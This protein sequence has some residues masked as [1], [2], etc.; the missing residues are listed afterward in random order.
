MGSVSIEESRR[1]DPILY[2]RFSYSTWVISANGGSESLQ[3][4]WGRKQPGG[5]NQEVERFSYISPVIGPIVAF[6]DRSPIRC[7]FFFSSFPMRRKLGRK[8]G[9][10]NS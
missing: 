8:C 4:L 7:I 3:P 2:T 6:P 5:C 10:E 9:V 1:M